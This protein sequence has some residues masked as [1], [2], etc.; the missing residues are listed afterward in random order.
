MKMI[1]ENEAVKEMK[2]NLLRKVKAEFDNAKGI[3]GKEK[4]T[5]KEL[6][7]R[8]GGEEKEVIE[9]TLQQMG[10]I[11]EEEDGKKL[12]GFVFK[13]CPDKL[14]FGGAGLQGLYNTFIK[15][16]ENESNINSACEEMDIKVR[17]TWGKG[18]RDQKQI[19][20]D[21]LI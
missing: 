21:L 1:N 4:I 19:Y 13:E 9:L 8:F 10:V 16:Y 17:L 11:K 18:Y 7:D 14:Y 3:Q 20:V 5:T 12:I 6:F 2:M 15:N